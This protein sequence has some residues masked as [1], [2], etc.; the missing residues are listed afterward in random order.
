MK[1]NHTKQNLV[2]NTVHDWYRF[3]LAYPDHL[4]ANLIQQFD[5]G[6]HDIVL[7]PF[8]GTGTTLVECKKHGIPSIGVDAN[9]VAAFASRVKTNWDIDIDELNDR[10]GHFLSALSNS[11]TPHQVE[12]EAAD[13]LSIV[14]KGAIS[15]QPLIKVLTARAILNDLP[16]DSVTDILRLA[17]S[18][19]AVLDMSNLG[20]GPEVYV[21]KKKKSDADLISALSN[22]LHF[23]WCDLNEVQKI[24]QAGSTAVYLG[25]ARQLNTI[26][27]IDN[28]DYVIT[29][30][31]YPNEKD[32]TRI[33]RLELVLLSFIENKAD[34]REVKE[35]MLRSHTRNIYRSDDDSQY[36]QDVPEIM[37]LAA[38][39]ED[40][41][42]KRNATSGFEK[43]Y[44]RVVTEYFGGMYRALEQLQ[45][46]MSPGSRL[47]FVV[48]DQMSYFRIPIR[49]AELLGLVASKKLN[50]Q[51]LDIQLWRTRMATATKKTVQEHI[52]LLERV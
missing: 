37:D 14:P 28:A 20:F 48:G 38:E 23:I 12:K 47:A 31:P 13:L 32:Y 24:E 11:T 35:L 40:R 39:I 50:Y 45:R 46:I 44:H 3:V 29:S 30:P 10:S 25:D 4:V 9:P 5:I 7:D 19:V 17:L 18:S 52:L 16:D 15:P 33:T 51:Q 22:R 42:I 2:D 34:L 27:E 43:L 8:V 49:T 26:L 41:R 36:V 1:T 21:K 6:S